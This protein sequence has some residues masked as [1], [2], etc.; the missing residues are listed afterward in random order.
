MGV[1]HGEVL[2]RKQQERCD[3]KEKQHKLATLKVL[4]ELVAAPEVNGL[5][6]DI[7]LGTN[8]EETKCWD[9]SYSCWDELY[10]TTS[11]LVIESGY[12]KREKFYGVW[13]D[14][15]H[16]DEPQKVQP[17]I[18]LVSEYRLEERPLRNLIAKLK[19]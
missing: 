6:K 4:Q 3:L 7:K 13:D 14:L 17:S 16:E 19:A 2:T 18:N 15:H 9:G 5:I 12:D 1:E 11:G 8:P 10:L